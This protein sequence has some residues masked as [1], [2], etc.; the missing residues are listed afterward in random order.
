MSIQ[1]HPP[2]VPNG[3]KLG[4]KKRVHRNAHPCLVFLLSRTRVVR[5]Y[6]LS[7]TPAQH[8][9]LVCSGVSQNQRM[10]Y[11]YDVNMKLS[12][13][14]RGR[15]QHENDATDRLTPGVRENTTNVLM[16]AA[17]PSR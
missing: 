1:R 13:A 4:H 8:P 2:C 5:S 3:V 6:F 16:S 14:C 12:T 9:R 15:A 11:L 10:Y 7:R 17:R